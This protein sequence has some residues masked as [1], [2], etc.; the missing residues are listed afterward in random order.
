MIDVPLSSDPGIPGVVCC[1]SQRPAT[2]NVRTYSGERQPGFAYF[3]ALHIN[4]A[5]AENPFMQEPE[6]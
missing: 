6:T 5:I 1:G 3:F 4:A 2:G